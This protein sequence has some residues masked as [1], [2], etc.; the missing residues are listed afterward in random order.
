[1]TDPFVNPIGDSGSAT[2]PSLL[3]R[4][5]ANET[6]A[7]ERLVSL[8]TPLL[9]R[10]CRH[11]GLQ[12][13]DAADI[14]QKVFL[15]VA[16]KIGT[17]HPGQAVG[18]FRRWLRTITR[19]KVVDHWRVEAARAAPGGS[20]AYEQLQ[21]LSAPEPEDTPPGLEAEE[22]GLLYRRAAELIA[23]D[24]EE[25]TWQAFVMV[26]IED[27]RPADVAADLGVST[28]AVYLARARVLGRLREEFAGLIDP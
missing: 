14:R 6:P 21:R 9:D 18:S 27:R 2:S 7:W 10:W 11:Y 26:V 22:V 12:E 25:R 20:S 15:A 5:R 19:S 3:E 28:N 13:A 23:R 8:Y 16:E 24:F 1:M 4:V 17:F